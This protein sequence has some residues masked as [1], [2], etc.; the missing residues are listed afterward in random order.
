[1]C[2][3]RRIPSPAS[4]RRPISV[5]ARL[6]DV[7]AKVL[8]HPVQDVEG[9]Q[10]GLERLKIRNAPSVADHGLVVESGRTDPQLL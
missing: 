4:R 9:V 3:L 5:P 10:K 2:S 7:P 1:M 6:P 8:A